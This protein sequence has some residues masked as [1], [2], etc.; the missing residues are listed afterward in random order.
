M[1][2][3]DTVVSQ[4]TD[5]V[6]MTELVCEPYLGVVCS[7]Y[8][9]EWQQQCLSGGNEWSIVVA[10]N[11]KTQQILE[12]EII[13]LQQLLDGK[14]LSHTNAYCYVYIFLL[15]GFFPEC[16]D[17]VMPYLCIYSFRL[18]NC[19]TA[20]SSST[21]ADAMSPLYATT[22]TQE[23]CIKIRSDSVCAGPWQIAINNDFNLPD[24]SSLPHRNS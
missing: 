14:I 16:H 6:P 20:S 18:S 21:P 12:K 15:L 3:C 7:S 17:L 13:E 19:Q 11:V 4:N 5:D 8:L 9:K 24:C 23:E 1:L 10:E 22:V 2:I